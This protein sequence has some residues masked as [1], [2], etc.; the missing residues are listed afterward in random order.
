MVH[1]TSGRC[2]VGPTCDLLMWLFL[3]KHMFGW[4]G[5]ATMTLEV[6]TSS[7]RFHLLSVKEKHVYKTPMTALMKDVPGQFGSNQLLKDQ[8]FS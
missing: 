7:T 6:L 1:A 3:G 8:T 5:M 2:E 4:S